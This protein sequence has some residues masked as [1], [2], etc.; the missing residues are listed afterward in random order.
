MIS[1]CRGVTGTVHRLCLVLMVCLWLHGCASMSIPPLLNYASMALSGISYIS[2]SKGPSDH[3]ISYVT[4]KD[5][6]LLR[7][8]ALKPVCIEVTEDSNQPIWVTLLKKKPDEF[9]N[10]IPMPPRIYDLT[11]PE[12]ANLN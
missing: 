6:S 5:C 3:A 9:P 12:V 7:A 10:E 11:D 4:K 1:Q 2:T 8:L